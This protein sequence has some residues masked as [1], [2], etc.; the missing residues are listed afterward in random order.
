PPAGS[1]IVVVCDGQTPELSEQAA[2]ALAAR[3]SP[4]PK[5]FHAD[6]RPDAGPF[7]AQNGLL[8][9]STKDVQPA[10]AQLI[11]AE[12]F[13]GPMAADPSMR[14]L[15]TTLSTTLQGVSGGQASLSDLR[16]P[17]RRLADVL[18]SLRAGKPT[19]FSWR[20]LITPG[21][22]DPRELRHVILVDPSLEFAR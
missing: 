20:A 3:L 4:Q 21:A 11:K 6:R 18:E 15:M 7:W 19:F 13:L 1:Q 17:I 9:A 14:G 8:Y 5:L 10:M 2:A 12:P 22:L 16:N